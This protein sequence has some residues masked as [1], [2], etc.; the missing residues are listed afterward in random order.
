MQDVVWSDAL[1]D[2]PEAL[3]TW[4]RKQENKVP[5]IRES[6]R[7]SIVWADPARKKKTDYALVYL[8]G[9][10]ASHPEG[11]PIHREVARHFGWNLYLSRLEGHGLE[12]AKP[13]MNLRSSSLKRSAL[14][15]LA[16]G[17]KLGN[18]I[19]LMGTSTGGSLSLFL[20]TQPQ[21]KKNIRALILYSPLIKFYGS[22]QWLLG[23]HVGRNLLKLIPGKHYL[24]TSEPGFSASEKEIWYQ[25]Y[26]LQG[27]FALGEFIQET[28]TPSLFSKVNIP[29]FTGYYYKNSTEQDKVVSVEAIKS[30]YEYL[31]TP[32]PQKVLK[33][34]P[35]VGTHVI[36]FG[37]LSKSIEEIKSDTIGFLED[38]IQ[39]ATTYAGN[40]G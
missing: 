3:D 5:N 40:P 15:A 34:Y 19:I 10:K 21:L 17:Q 31:A 7:A 33:N 14:Q 6:A 37:L 23:N 8:H 4:L 9:F 2:K 29:I 24:L 38:H 20:A 18:N 25:S 30:M 13:L 11:S 1:P 35:E 12:V 16:V 39:P 32:E 28:M 22:N 27:A 36:C 26:A